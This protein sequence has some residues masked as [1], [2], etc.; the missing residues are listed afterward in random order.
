M[1]NSRKPKK[2]ETSSRKEHTIRSQD[3][4]Y[5]RTAHKYLQLASIGKIGQR[6]N[7]GM[8]LYIKLHV[9]KKSV[10]NP[11]QVREEGDL[12]ARVKDQAIRDK[13]SVIPRDAIN[14]EHPPA[15]LYSFT[16]LRDG[17]INNKKI[18]NV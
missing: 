13:A 10:D 15:N 17:L 6:K 8:G 5:V 18:I 12:K 2:V 11:T 1:V 9:L 7:I 3:M 4:F 14:A 16:V